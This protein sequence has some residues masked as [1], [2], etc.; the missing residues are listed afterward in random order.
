MATLTAFRFETVDAADN[1]LGV[2]SMLQALRVLGTLD[3]CDQKPRT[4]AAIVATSPI[5]SFTI[6]LESAPR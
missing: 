4:R 5:P 3:P 6:S 1:A 2:I